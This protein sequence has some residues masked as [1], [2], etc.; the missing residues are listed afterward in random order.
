MS[1]GSEAPRAG[2]A[3]TRSAVTIAIAHGKRMWG[4]RRRTR[5]PASVKKLPYAAATTGP[6]ARTSADAASALSGSAKR[7][8]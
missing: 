6:P 2:A 8:P 5:D 3:L 4:D 1:S 7:K